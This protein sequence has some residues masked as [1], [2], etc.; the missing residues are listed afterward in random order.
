VALDVWDETGTYVGIGVANFINVFNP[1]V[2]AVGG[3]IAK[4][5]EPLFRAVRRAAR[6]HAIPTLFERCRIEPAERLDDAGVLGAA[7]LAA[8]LLPLAA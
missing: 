2:V 6:N 4:A 3:Q 8:A 5:G 1:E 7:A